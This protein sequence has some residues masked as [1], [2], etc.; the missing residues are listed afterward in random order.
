MDFL[1]SI[2][3]V[4]A[5][6]VTECDLQCTTHKSSRREETQVNDNRDHNKNVNVSITCHIWVQFGLLMSKCEQYND[7]NCLNTNFSSNQNI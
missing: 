7:E 1:I 2:N 5:V 3:T 6:G 4:Y